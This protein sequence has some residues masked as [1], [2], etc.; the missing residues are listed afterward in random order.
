MKR[1]ILVL[2]LFSATLA[3]QAVKPK[4]FW[5]CS[6][7]KLILIR[8]GLCVPPVKPVVVCPIVGPSK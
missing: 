3:A 2:M 5:I 8:Q 6:D 4:C 7:G 1:F